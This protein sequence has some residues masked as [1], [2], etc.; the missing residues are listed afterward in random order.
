MT[1]PRC[2]FLQK[3][4]KRKCE[5]HEVF[6]GRKRKKLCDGV[7]RN[8]KK[9]MSS[10]RGSVLK[11]FLGA[12]VLFENSDG[13]ADGKRCWLASKHEGQTSRK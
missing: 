9:L 12:D 1:V 2:L 8:R 4:H 3:V 11:F 13:V 5:C 6:G 10:Y 7:C